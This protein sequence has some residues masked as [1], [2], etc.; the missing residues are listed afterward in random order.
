MIVVLLTNLERGRNGKR[1]CEAKVVEIIWWLAYRAARV[2]QIKAIIVN[3]DSL[4][5]H[6]LRLSI[7]NSFQSCRG[8]LRSCQGCVRG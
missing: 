2:D 7:T 4:H 8:E 5:S 3:L 1:T 6:T